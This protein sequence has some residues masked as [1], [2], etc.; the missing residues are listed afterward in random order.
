MPKHIEPIVLVDSN[1]PGI[2][3][4]VVTPANSITLDKGF[5]RI[6]MGSGCYGM[7]ALEF[8]PVI[9][10]G[11]VIVANSEQVIYVPEDNTVFGCVKGTFS[12]NDGELSI[13]PLLVWEMPGNFPPNY[14]LFL[15]PV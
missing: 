9:T 13:N 4:E 7:W 11:G 14:S 5:Y 10:N 8:L 2:I 12:A 15:P 3:Y 1:E 6:A